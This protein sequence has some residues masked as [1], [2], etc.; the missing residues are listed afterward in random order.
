MIP[1]TSEPGVLPRAIPTGRALGILLAF[2]AAVISGFSI[3]VNSYAV[4]EVSDPAVFTSAKNATVG[5]AFIAIVLL[6]APSRRRAV[7]RLTSRQ[8]VA[9]AAV[10][11]V[12]G[13]VPFVLFFE[14]LS[15][16]GPGNGAFI[17][18]TLFIWVAL[19][20]VPL[21]RERVGAWQIFALAMLGV[22]QYFVGKPGSWEPGKGELMV[23][24]ATWLWA[25]EAIVAR[26]VL[27]AIGS[28]LGATARMG[29]GGALLLC[30]LGIT[31]KVDD[32]LALD[33]HQWAWVV[34]TSGI[35]AVYVSTWYAA[36]RHAPATVV[37]SVLT[38]G[39]PITA[40]L[41]TWSGKPGP[42]GEQLVG[43]GLVIFAAALMAASTMLPVRRAAPGR[44]VVRP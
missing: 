44:A 6:N 30:Y 36:L 12:G 25:I 23:L 21:L 37:T 19:L 8:W 17:Q 26:S 28:S 41:S 9:L 4:K 11:V 22:A 29:L 33:A 2:A 24:A 16:A 14:G 31:G 43:Y 3:W 20:A 38:L 32:L 15:Q 42:T 1:R 27:P 18:K 7:R 34:G 35:L 13:S 5:M 39:A 40:A 10:G